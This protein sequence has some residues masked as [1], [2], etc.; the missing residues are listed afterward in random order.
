MGQLKFQKNIMHF[1]MMVFFFLLIAYFPALKNFEDY[2]IYF[3]TALFSLHFWYGAVFLI[4][5]LGPT[6]NIFEFPID[7]SILA[8]KVWSIYT[9]TIMPLWFLVNGVLMG[10]GVLKY[11]LASKRGYAK[12]KEGYILKKIAIELFSVSA[13]FIAA[14][15]AWRLD[16]V[17]FKRILSVTALGIQFPFLFWM[18]FKKKVY[19]IAK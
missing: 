4:K 10:F 8:L 1:F 3:A 5:T 2:F 9:I 7:F 16:I 14:V 19:K 11:H 6:K 13:F 15:L 17:L 12:K 18:F